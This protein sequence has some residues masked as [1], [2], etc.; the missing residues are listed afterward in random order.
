[1]YRARL[2]S[3]AGCELTEHKTLHSRASHTNT[4]EASPQTDEAYS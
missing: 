1:M 2:N 4:S 3:L